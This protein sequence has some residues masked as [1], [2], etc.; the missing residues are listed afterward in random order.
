MIFI[1]MDSQDLIKGTAQYQIRYNSSSPE[2]SS[3]SSPNLRVREQLNFLGSLR[4]PDIWASSRERA[5]LMETLRNVHGWGSFGSQRQAN[6]GNPPRGENE[7]FRSEELERRPLGI[8]RAPSRSEN[9]YSPQ[10][11]PAVEPSVNLENCDWPD[12]EL[13]S[14]SADGNGFIPPP[15]IVTTETD[16]ESSDGEEAPSAAV[17]ADRLRRDSRWMA[18]TDEE[19]D[20]LGNTNIFWHAHHESR[21]GGTGYLRA[22]QRNTPSRIGPKETT[23]D[24]TDSLLAPHARFFIEK[25]KSRISIKFDPPV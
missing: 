6:R 18:D 17:M 10:P 25:N 1:S 3:A 21:F 11:G 16:I 19:D 23:S 4:N 24:D 8:F 15:F 13:P 7:H 22:S 14:N 12:V 20:D 9:R 5:R 2:S